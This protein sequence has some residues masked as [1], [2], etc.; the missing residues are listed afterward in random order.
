MVIGNTK[1][2]PLTFNWEEEE[3]EN[4]HRDLVEQQIQEQRRKE[5]REEDS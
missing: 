3:S 2:N 4:Y 1:I 5:E